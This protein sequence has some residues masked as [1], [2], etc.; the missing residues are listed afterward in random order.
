[1][2]NVN[3]KETKRGNALL[4]EYE[5]E[6]TKI[7]LTPDT[8]QKYL[9][10]SNAKITEQEFVLFAALC[11]AQG[12]NPFTRDAYLIKYSDKDSA[13]IV[14]SKDVILKRAVN[15]SQ[16]DGKESG[17]IVKIKESGEIIEKPGCFV[18][19]KTEELIG[20]WCRVYRKDRKY[21]EYMSVS[22]A[23]VGQKKAD[24]TLNYNWGKKTATMLEKVAKVR[25]LREA[26]VDELAG[27]YEEDEFVKETNKE[28]QVQNQEPQADP[29]EDN[30]TA[31]AAID[32]VATPKDEKVDINAL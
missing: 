12:L 9:V 23:E 17:V 10:G 21:P 16:Y 20:G 26:F 29:F 18:D 5:V 27:M 3:N 13:Q 32:V 11:K 1:M 30:K 28:P 14:V 25:A 2:S 4:V 24:G 31:D 8:V 6:N 19:A 7:K 22:L 15:H